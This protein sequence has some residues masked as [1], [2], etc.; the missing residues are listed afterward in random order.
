[1]NA[2]PF[3]WLDGKPNTLRYHL[4][5]PE[6]SSAAYI[7]N[8]RVEHGRHLLSMR[9][10]Y[11]DTKYW[12]CLREV[13]IGRATRS[14]Q[15]IFDKLKKLR[16]SRK[17]ICP[18]SYSVFVELLRQSDLT[19]RLATARAVDIFG[20][21]SCIQAP[22]EVFCQEILGF[23]LKYENLGQLLNRM[24]QTNEL[25][26]VR[27]LIWSKVSFIVGLMQ[28]KFKGCRPNEAEALEKAIDDLFWSMSLEEMMS[29]L[30]P[31]NP[32]GGR[33]ER[34]VFA[35]KLTSGA[36]R[37]RRNSDTFE[38]LFLDEVAGGLDAHAR[39]L[40][41]I[42]EYL[43]RKIGFTG[44]ASKKEWKLAGRRLGNVIRA[45][46]ESRKISTE[47]PAVHIP[48]GLH[49]AVRFDRNRKYKAN[50]CEDFRHAVVALPYYDIFCTEKSLRHLLCHKPLEYDKAYKTQ[51]VSND[52]EVLAALDAV[53]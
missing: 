12:V 34:D 32:E 13:L 10:I 44:K 40:G 19:T 45:A 17:I 1:M 49:A 30:A 53:A 27:E 28:P 6:I 16:A 9:R 37:A 11:L 41:Q 14:Q 38:K 8:R 50:D 36:N 20:E 33:R 5:N 2:I 23:C 42:M 18:I 21:S 26:P 24:S 47:V 46:F 35:V 7:R 52:E 51:V 31:E 29:V 15:A 39:D 4:D 3:P 22:N 43:S 25:T 48:S